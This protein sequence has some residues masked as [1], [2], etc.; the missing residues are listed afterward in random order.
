MQISLIASALT[1]GFS[2][3]AQQAP[4]QWKD[5]GQFNCPAGSR[6]SVKCASNTYES[7][8]A[9][10]VFQSGAASLV[11]NLYDSGGRIIGSILVSTETCH[12]IGLGFSAK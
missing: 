8:N 9:A 1:Y 5:V 6:C 11:V 2:A 12:F 3:A 10:V 7:I 4:Q